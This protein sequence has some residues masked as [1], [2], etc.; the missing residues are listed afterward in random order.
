MYQ[1]ANPAVTTTP[2]AIGTY[3][4]GTFLTRANNLSDVAVVAT[5]RT[6]LGLGPFATMTFPAA[7]NLLGSSGS[8][9]TPVTVGSGLSLSGGTLTATAGGGGT[10]TATGTQGTNTIPTWTATA[11]QLQA[12]GLVYGATPTNGL[13]QTTGNVIAAAI[14]PNTTATAGN[15]SAS[16]ITLQADGRIS[17]AATRVPYYIG[18]ISNSGAGNAYI[19]SIAGSV[20]PQNPPTALFDG[21]TLRV[22][23]AAG[24]TNNTG[25]MT[26]NAF[27]LGAIA[28]YRQSDAG[29]NSALAGNEFLNTNQEYT[30]IY[31]SGVSGFV[32]TAFPAGGVTVTGTTS[33]TTALLAVGWSSGHFYDVTGAGV[34][35]AMPA[36]SSLGTQGGIFINTITNSATLTAQGTDTITNSAG[37]TAAAG[38]VTLAAGNLYT[39]TSNGAGSFLVNNPSAVGGTPVEF[40]GTAAGTST[41]YTM[42]TTTP[43]GFVLT[44]NYKVCGQFPIASGNAPTL[45]VGGTAAKAMVKQAGGALVPLGLSDIPGTLSQLCFQVDPTLTYYVMLTTPVSANPITVSDTV[46]PSKWAT[47]QPYVINTA[48]QTITLPSVA[49]LGTGGCISIQTMAQ[50][51][52]LTPAATDGIDGAATGTSVVISA[53]L[54]TVVT[55]PTG[56]PGFG[57]FVVPLGPVQGK[58]ITWAPGQFLPTTGLPIGRTGG[59][60][61]VATAVT[62]TVPVAAGGAGPF[63]IDVYATPSPTA[64]TSGTKLDTTPCN[65]AVASATEQPMG[66]ANTVIPPNSWIWIVATSWPTGTTS[67]SAGGL[68]LSYR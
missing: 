17:A 51:V 33:P 42:A 11:N 57:T 9:F 58:D 15:Y 59:S 4:T 7:A 48:G 19:F 62:C 67:L 41:A 12:A 53:D 34:T 29:A 25:A 61:R 45:S 35:F 20:G 66:V 54:T 32:N 49:T 8:A 30:L 36:L 16:D 40:I 47:C 10:V 65:A 63:N 64:P 3:L 37:V 22:R 1:G 46:T 39:V 13:V 26:V 44:A 27:G 5:A 18:T 56:A 68:T 43:T 60:P 6:N 38:S 24:A 28:V 2:A 50:T 31:N 14:I 21:L 52:T 55:T 23:L